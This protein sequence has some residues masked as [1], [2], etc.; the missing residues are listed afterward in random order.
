MSSA[1][2]VRSSI[3]GQFHIKSR[4]KPD[5]DLCGLVLGFVIGRISKFSVAV[6][7]ENC[8]KDI[9][10]VGDTRCEPIVSLC[11]ALLIGN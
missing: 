2:T 4:R 3:G 7:E 11:S 8:R 1:K 9:A 10:G 6:V 5:R